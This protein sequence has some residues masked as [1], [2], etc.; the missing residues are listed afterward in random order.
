M[1]TKTQ[2]LIL[3]FP[4]FTLSSFINSSQA[5]CT[6]RGISV[7]WGQSSDS[8]EGTLEET[9]KSGNYSIV[10][11]QYL[12]VYAS[13][14]DPTFNLAGHCGSQDKPC[15]ILES[16]IQTCQSLNIKVFLSIGRDVVGIIPARGVENKTASFIFDNFLSGKAGPLGNVTLDGVNIFTVN[17]LILQWDVII[18]ALHSYATPQ[19]KIYLSASPQCSDLFFQRDINTGLLDYIFVQFYS[20]PACQYDRILLNSTLLLKSWKLWISKP[21][22]SNAL[23]FMGLPASPGG[24]ILSN[25]FIEADVLRRD[26]LPTV[27]Q[28]FNYGGIML[29]DKAADNKTKY[30]DAI[31]DSVPKSCTC[32]CDESFPF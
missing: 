2:T 29:Y 14:R 4:L 8:E 27:Q 32:F 16:Q 26:T 30:S 19:K 6:P 12:T 31:K 3:L 20:N 23:V 18:R 25:G 10:M 9:C 28:A 7:Y 21:E 1:A 17:N 24:L 13:G 5:D 22:L 11:I 15:T